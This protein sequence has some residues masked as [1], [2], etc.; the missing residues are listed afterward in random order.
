MLNYTTAN[1]VSILLAR[2]SAAGKEVV[3]YLVAR[4]TLYKKNLLHAFWAHLSF[5][6]E[7]TVKVTVSWNIASDSSKLTPTFKLW[8]I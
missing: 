6:L 7:A 2:L 8:Y 4:N 3:L 5:S 1:N